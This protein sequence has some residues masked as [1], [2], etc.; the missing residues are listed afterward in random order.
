MD[1]FAD[2]LGDTR[3]HLSN[4]ERDMG[5]LVEVLIANNH[6]LETRLRVMEARATVSVFQKFTNLSHF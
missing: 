2:Q 5:L 6:W 1:R 4:V 3:N